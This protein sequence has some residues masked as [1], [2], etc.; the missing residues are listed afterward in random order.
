MFLVLLDF[1]GGDFEE[2][3]DASLTSMNF[4]RSKCFKDQAKPSHEMTVIF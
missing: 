4:E 1:Q 3:E 2:L